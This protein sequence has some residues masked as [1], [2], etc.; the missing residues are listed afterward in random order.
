MDIRTTEVSMMG[1]AI[2]FVRGAKYLNCKR[3]ISGIGSDAKSMS[4]TM[5][6]AVK[7]STSKT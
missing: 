4:V 7:F 1:I 2:E 3:Q 6:N 5:L